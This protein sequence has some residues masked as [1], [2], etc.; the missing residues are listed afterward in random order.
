MPPL[1]NN[2]LDKLTIFEDERP[3]RQLERAA[4]RGELATQLPQ[5]DDD[6]PQS[7]HRGRQ[8]RR[9]ASG[10]GYDT[11]PPYD[12][13]IDINDNPFTNFFTG[14][15]VTRIPAHI[16]KGFLD[17]AAGDIEGTELAIR[18]MKEAGAYADPNVRAAFLGKVMMDAE[19]EGIGSLT[20]IGEM[21][22]KNDL[23]TSDATAALRSFELEPETIRGEILQGLGSA[24]YFFTLAGIALVAS[25]GNPAVARASA[26][27]A[28]IGIG[29]SE[30]WR[31]VIEDGIIEPSEAA[32][33][34]PFGI[35][36]GSLEGFM[37]ARYFSF[38]R[39]AFGG[40]AKGNLAANVLS[41][42][43]QEGATEAV[44]T[45][46][47]NGASESRG[48]LEGVGRA[49]I[50]GGAVGG[51]T[52][53]A[54]GVAMQFTQGMQK[55]GKALTVEKKVKRDVK[56]I[57]SDEEI[58][59]PEVQKIASFL[60]SEVEL[61]VDTAETVVEDTAEVVGV[62]EQMTQKV[63]EDGAA[64]RK[65]DSRS[66]KRTR[67]RR[68]VLAADESAHTAP[69]APA[70]VE[71]A[72]L[73]Q[74]AVET[75]SDGHTD[76]MT[77]FTETARL[78]SLQSELKAV[79]AQLRLAE[80]RVEAQQDIART[81]GEA[82][83]RQ[84]VETNQ[85]LQDQLI[86]LDK[87][88][89]TIEAELTQTQ[90][91]LTEAEAELV[92]KDELVSKGKVEIDKQR[93]LRRNTA[94]REK[95]AKAKAA[96]L[97]EEVGAL[98]RQVV[99]LEGIQD[100]NRKDIRN[101]KDRE[102]RA[103]R[104]VEELKAEIAAAP[105]KETVGNLE[106]QLAQQFQ[107]LTDAQAAVKAAEL[108]AEQ[109]KTLETDLESLKQ[110]HN[111]VL[112]EYKDAQ[113]E[114][115]AEKRTA[116]S[117]RSELIELQKSE[118]GQALEAAGIGG[119][120]LHVFEMEE[121]QDLRTEFEDNF[122][123]L[124]A[125]PGIESVKEL[126]QEEEVEQ[127]TEAKE[128]LDKELN[129]LEGRMDFTGVSSE[130]KSELK[131]IRARLDELT[132][133]GPD[134][135]QTVKQ[136]ADEVT[137]KAGHL[138]SEKR[139]VEELE[140]IDKKIVKVEKELAAIQKELEEGG[141]PDTDLMLDLQDELKKLTAKRAKLTESIPDPSETFD[142]KTNQVLAPVQQ[143]LAKTIEK[144]ELTQDEIA[145]LQ[146]VYHAI[147]QAR[148]QSLTTP[149]D[150][151]INTQA[152]AETDLKRANSAVEDAFEQ[153]PPKIQK[154]LMKLQASLAKDV[155]R[156]KKG[157]VGSRLNTITALVNK[158][159]ADGELGY[160]QRKHVGGDTVLDG[161]DLVAT[162]K[163]E[164]MRGNPIPLQRTS[165]YIKELYQTAPLFNRYITDMDNEVERKV[166]ELALIQAAQDNLLN[167]A[168]VG[169]II[170][171]TYET[172]GLVTL[173]EQVAM[174]AHKVQEF[175]HYKN[176]VAKEKVVQGD[177]NEV[178]KIRHEVNTTIERM[179]FAQEAQ[180]LVA[181]R[182][183][184]QLAIHQR[185]SYVDGTSIFRLHMQAIVSMYKKKGDKKKIKAFEQDLA[186]WDELTKKQEDAQS[187][188]KAEVARLSDERIVKLA[189]EVVIPVSARPQRA[190][191]EAFARFA[192]SAKGDLGRLNFGL[193]PKGLV[194][195]ARLTRD[196]LNAGYI[197]K[198]N[199]VSKLIEI[200]EQ[201]GGV[202]GIN[203]ITEEQARV[204]IEIAMSKEMDAIQEAGV[205]AEEALPKINKQLTLFIK[206][207]EENPTTMGADLLSSLDF[208]LEKFK[209]KVYQ[210]LWT[211][212][213]SEKVLNRINAIEDYI[214]SKRKILADEELSIET[215]LP[216][217]TEFIEQLK[218]L[219]EDQRIVDARYKARKAK[220]LMRA[221]SAG[222][223]S[224]N[225]YQ[226][227]LIEAGI[228]SK[229]RGV[230]EE[231]KALQKEI[232]GYVAEKARIVRKANHA[233]DRL[234]STGFEYWSGQIAHAFRVPLTIMDLGTI[235]RQ[236]L[237]FLTDTVA[238]KRA[239]ISSIKAAASEDRARE[240]YYGIRNL[241]ATTPALDHGLY[242]ATPD[243]A[244]TNQEEFAP[245]TFLEN[246]PGLGP[247]IRGSA[248]QFTTYMNTVRAYQSMHWY[249]NFAQP[250]L[251]SETATDA[252]K[253]D[254]LERSK[255]VMTYIN[256][257]SGRG[258]L[259][260]QVSKLASY[261][262]FAPRFTAS[263]F[264]AYGRAVQMMQSPETRKF[265]AKQIAF[266]G[267]MLTFQ[268]G[269][270][271]AT[272]GI[273]GTDYEDPDFG[274][275]VLG[276][277]HIDM[278]GGFAQPLR[279]VMKIV[280]LAQRQLGLL[281]EDR[282][283]T[284][285][286]LNDTLNA[287]LLLR[288]N[289][290]L[291]YVLGLFRDENVV[292]EPHSHTN[293]NPFDEIENPILSRTTPLFAQDVMDAWAEYGDVRAVGVGAMSLVGLSANT[294]GT[295][296]NTPRFTKLFREKGYRVPVIRKTDRIPASDEFMEEM[297][298]DYHK[299]FA[300]YVDAYGIDLLRSM[301]AED[302]KKQLR[303]IAKQT[304]DSITDY[305]DYK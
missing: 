261:G 243:E 183:G 96:S 260:A 131:K 266:L 44:Q 163:A 244:L 240:S 269:L 62:L 124:G 249:N 217:I 182:S 251:E 221:H 161:N 128:A 286:D 165:E 236:G 103:K 224:T 279:L 268:M 94:R 231:T 2:R 158:A 52:G 28:G 32:R 213:E 214:S 301:P 159:V 227:E 254:I 167:N 233:R 203:S 145:L 39:N 295:R 294:Y 174:E 172:N 180:D 169:E 209:G 27:R 171:K 85:R 51:I 54:G 123:Q 82:R 20:E 37:S 204:A 305:Y 86:S 157:T 257:L 288:L 201:Q 208:V 211:Q 100:R 188:L 168:A 41:L 200:V 245:T 220:E 122:A 199:T 226:D 89:Q 132:T 60:E 8:A 205:K 25:G 290:T 73:P 45:L 291:G 48:L 252:E 68:K 153:L 237:P 190:T 17:S 93:T 196:L 184:Q 191:M 106:A 216:A 267:S 26:I 242:L 274:K 115:D 164:A 175:E 230:S 142:A 42:A 149:T 6:P 223:L 187:R 258:T 253:A 178:L 186:A 49:G 13:N 114:L 185:V 264:E 130:V 136:A 9:R 29:V 126:D 166:Y 43:A 92:K 59:E 104:S 141:F 119:S 181:S 30:S 113:I 250:V 117:L 302:A 297:N 112:K 271:R 36:S 7:G 262:L 150:T 90:G 281:P 109:H 173:E 129:E 76:V 160:L 280:Y 16:L 210:L 83:S 102:R 3:D 222:E 215:K 111:A 56:L 285:R 75:A 300:S 98:N 207:L 189:E 91:S 275:I 10:S 198:R 11:W 138:K 265:A 282:L 66:V 79:K 80:K 229:P 263:R 116:A 63:Q 272:V 69:T 239:L 135:G 225:Q 277:T 228:K 256:V 177:V 33:A 235:F 110:D 127:S 108:T 78:N 195:L 121:T 299:M 72:P 55:A 65:L 12:T 88:K 154:P 50:V 40:T 152:D 77:G 125:D 292:G 140:K 35:A 197:G 58:S 81:S 67:A 23:I 95:R 118:T 284:S 53:G 146:E 283:V 99:K 219:P 38:L 202:Y 101:A 137:Q 64:F 70:D 143:Q 276:N 71:P 22:M 74:P 255:S 15:V 303:A 1:S 206:A 87:R 156:K 84:Y 147:G 170:A 5:P 278:W 97:E 289:P 21:L 34:T 46:I 287:F 241:V 31:G 139:R 47:V 148:A 18:T 259:P 234:T 296:V 248:R 144:G 105:D 247:L 19:S 61:E 218:K 57:R 133:K 232:S 246:V 179:L 107:E 176:L 270:A 151:E 194:P 120:D 155:K 193:D 273:V 162:V 212:K 4:N 238:T 298:K 192:E 24:A 304:K 293:L 134:E 14:S